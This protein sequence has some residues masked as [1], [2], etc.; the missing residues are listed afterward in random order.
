MKCAVR[1]AILQAHRAD[2]E[3]SDAQIA[4]QLH[5]SAPYVAKVRKDL[6]Q[7]TIR[8]LYDSQGAEPATNEHERREKFLNLITSARALLFQASEYC[9]PEVKIAMLAKLTAAP[10]RE[11]REVSS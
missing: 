2:P 8:R 9:S 6:N 5:C 11:N 10:A 1:L 3:A 7:H 4:V